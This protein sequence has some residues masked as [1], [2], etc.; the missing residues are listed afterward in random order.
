L[1]EDES[2][3]A[4]VDDIELLLKVARHK[5]VFFHSTKA[6]YDKA[7]PGTLRLVPPTG[8]LTELERDYRQMQEMIFGEPPEFK[9]LLE[10]LR[11]IEHRVNGN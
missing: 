3:R 9:Y 4:A 7:K 6:Q 1:Y 2:G 8:R 5:D 11:E 10:V